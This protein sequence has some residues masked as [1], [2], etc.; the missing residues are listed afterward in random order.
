LKIAILHDLLDRKGGAERTLLSIARRLEDRGHDVSIF[1]LILEK[2]RTFTDLV[3]EVNVKEVGI[4]KDWLGY[5][6]AS[7]SSMRW[8][9]RNIFGSLDPTQQ[10]YLLYALRTFSRLKLEEYDIIHASNYPAS[11]AA[12]L[13]KKEQGVPAVWGCNEPYRDLWLKEY[14]TEPFLSRAANRT[15][16]DLLRFI[17]MRLVSSLDAIFVNSNYT[18]TLVERIYGRTSTVIYPGIDTRVYRPILDASVLK[19]HYCPEGGSLVLTVSRLYPAKK[20]DVLIRAVRRL[21]DRGER[22]KLLIIGEGPERER[23]QKLV[24]KL[25]LPREVIIE[26]SVPDEEMPRYF[27]AA[28]AF[29]FAAVDEPWGLVVLEAMA[30][31]LPVVVPSTG[32][33]NESVQEGVTGLQVDGREP[34]EYAEKLETILRNRTLAGR[35]GKAARSRVQREFD[36]KRTID[37]LEAFYLKTL[38]THPKN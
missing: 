34:K 21:K 31:G 17:D 13:L 32:G 28:D 9:L 7:R 33:P 26:G 29:A 24:H 8:R 1:T 30:C 4:L 25:E 22:V 16:G 6:G 12:A 38:E 35:I 10:L 14:S 15:V 37:S 23:L 3:E 19:E 5:S 20:I 11:N 36:L 18:R 2:E 27:S